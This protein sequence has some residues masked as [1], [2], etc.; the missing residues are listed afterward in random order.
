MCDNRKTRNSKRS[1]APAGVDIRTLLCPVKKVYEQPRASTP[2]VTACAPFRNE[3]EH[4]DP[5]NVEHLSTEMEFTNESCRSHFC[6]QSLRDSPVHMEI[7]RP[8]IPSTPQAAL[9]APSQTESVIVFTL[10]KSPTRTTSLPKTNAW[11]SLAALILLQLK[12]TVL[13]QLRQG[14]PRCF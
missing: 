11:T 4:E 5:L 9:F 3:R 1:D 2:A 12:C 13:H 10:D 6:E 14:V 7:S 8:A